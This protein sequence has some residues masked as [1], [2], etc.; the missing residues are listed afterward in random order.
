MPKI[1]TKTKRCGNKR[2]YDTLLKAQ[3]AVV[4][5]LKARQKQGNAVAVFLRAYGCPHCGKFHYGRTRNINWD[6]LK[7]K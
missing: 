7:E 3:E 5:L 2:S 1:K 4:I 6:L